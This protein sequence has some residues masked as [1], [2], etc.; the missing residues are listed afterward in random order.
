MP[1]RFTQK[2]LKD[3]FFLR[4]KDLKDVFFFRN[5][6]PCFSSQFKPERDRQN[7]PLISLVLLL[8]LLQRMLRHVVRDK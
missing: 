7:I 1:Y 3:V 8:V 6:P 4:Q 2:D 5:K